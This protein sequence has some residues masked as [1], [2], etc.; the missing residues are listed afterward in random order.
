[1]SE[2]IKNFLSQ[3]IE[4]RAFPSCAYSVSV[5]NETIFEAALGNAVVEPNLQRA[6]I[7]TIYD[8][9][10][11]TKVLVT[12]F[13]T[14]YLIETREILFEDKICK[15]FEVFDSGEQQEI[16]ILDLLT[17][18]SGFIGWKPFYLLIDERSGV[19]PLIASTP[20][21]YKL[22]SKVVYSDLN[23]LVLGFLIEKLLSKRLDEIAREYIFEKLKLENTFF[24]PPETV[25]DK[26]A[27]SE[28]GNLYERN[29]CIELGYEVT[30]RE[31]KFRR[32]VI[33]GE[34]HDNNCFHFGGVS[35]HAGL[36]STVNEVSKIA[37]QFLPETSQFFSAETCK[38]FTQNFT[39]GLNQAR[40]LAFQLAETPDSTAGKQLSPNSFG[41]LGFT[42]TSVWIDPQ[43]AAIFTLLTNRTHNRELPFADLKNI[44]QEFHSLASQA[45]VS[46]IRHRSS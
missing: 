31:D 5:G 12:G 28:R 41:H 46:G 14:A 10:S 42:G 26:T 44:R 37:A 23:F 6:A 3:K 40:S 21:D 22:R 16:T 18:R 9:A 17:H 38:T 30:L 25:F 36:F 20:P 8:L 39:P 27:A 24:N 11:L 45:L 33:H 35:G 7:T 1:M 13:L 2:A 19:L 29:T 32:N 43:T 4:E 15:F 34:V